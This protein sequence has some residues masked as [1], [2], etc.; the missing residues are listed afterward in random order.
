MQLQWDLQTREGAR[1]AREEIGSTQTGAAREVEDD[2]EGDA[3][4]R[5]EETETGDSGAEGA[6]GV[7]SRPR[8]GSLTQACARSRFG[9]FG[10]RGA[11]R[12]GSAA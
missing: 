9:F 4:E 1:L 8:L 2:S 12:R 3:E 7:G 5:S 10:F 6:A 11:A